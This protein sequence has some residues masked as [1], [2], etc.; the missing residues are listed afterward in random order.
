MKDET[1]YSRY[2]EVVVVMK[3]RELRDA[4]PDESQLA[5]IHRIGK[6]LFMHGG[7]TQL[8][9]RWQDEKFMKAD[10]DE[11]VEMVNQASRNDLWRN[12]SPLWFRPQYDKVKM[13]RTKVYKQVVG[14]TPVE[15]IYEE[16]GVISTDVF[17]TYSDG[18]QIG[19][20]AM[21]VIDTET[22]EF[23]KIEVPSADGG[24]GAGE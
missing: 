1:G 8:F 22:G 10:I 6:V 7:L 15:K 17:S 20:S 2:A 13:F 14:H 24:T 16:R 18:R 5:M 12:N 21:I 9:V 4:L 11:V 3:L 23:E 19:E